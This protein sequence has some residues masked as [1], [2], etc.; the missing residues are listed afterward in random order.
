MQALDRRGARIGVAKELTRNSPDA[1]T[2]IR[3]SS[4]IGFNLLI[5][6]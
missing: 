2:K 1:G 6:K 5:S 3:R 4:A